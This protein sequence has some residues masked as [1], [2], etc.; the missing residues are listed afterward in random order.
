[1]K[2]K[3]KKIAATA[4]AGLVGLHATTYL[5][6]ADPITQAEVENA[7]KPTSTINMPDPLVKVLNLINNASKW[8]MISTISIGLL[9]LIGIFIKEFFVDKNR[10]NIW[11]SLSKPFFI[12]LGVLLASWAITFVTGLFL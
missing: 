6:F 12:I 4:S 5:T 3:F 7:L 8:G 9:V 2:E 10:S 11:S 1:M